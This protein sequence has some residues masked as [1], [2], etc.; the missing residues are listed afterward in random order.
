M[1]KQLV[2]GIASAV[3]ISG[4]AAFATGT[5][6]FGALPSG[7][8]FSGSGIDASQV[9]FT[10]TTDGNNTITLGQSATSE[11]TPN[12]LGNNG[13]STF[14]ANT[15]IYKAN[16]ATWNFD[17]YA[18]ANVG[19]YTYQ[20]IYSL[21]PGGPTGT[22]VLGTGNLQNSENLGFGF[23]DTAS[24]NITP[25]TGGSFNPNATGDYTFTLEALN[26]SGN[27][28]ASDTIVVDVSNAPEVSSTALLFCLTLG[29]LGFYSRMRR[30]SVA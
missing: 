20:L 25:P 14:Y 16:Q 13:V 11:Y 1:K 7:N 17:F 6:S 18:S 3:L 2:F 26:T 15:G 10:T 29:G 4:S 12:T 5:P 30:Q 28:V 19:T 8:D 24:A 23:L 21:T 27:I 22:W 9:A